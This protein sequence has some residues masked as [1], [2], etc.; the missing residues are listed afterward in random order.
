MTR[1]DILRI[2]GS[3]LLSL[4]SR[5]SRA[6]FGAA[7]QRS[8]K[9]VIVIGAGIAG[10]SCAY[11]LVRR[12]HDVAVLEA[13]QRTGGHVRT[14]HDPLEDGLY[15]EV[16]AE[17]FNYPEYVQYWRYVKEFELTAL[18]HPL[19]VNRVRCLRDQRYTEEDLQRPAVLQELG[20]K[21]PEVDFLSEH[22][23]SDLPHLYVQPYIDKIR[24]ESDPFVDGLRALDDLSLTAFLKRE[25]AS[26]AAVEFFGSSGSAL[27][28]VWAAAL[29]KLRGA[30]YYNKQLYRLKDGNECMT[31]AFT[32]RLGGRVQLDCPVT[33]IEHG[34]SGVTVTYRKRGEKHKRDADY[35]VSAISL[36]NLRQIP[37]SPAWPEAKAYLIQELPYTIKARVVFQSRTRFWQTDGVTPN[38]VFSDPLLQD[39]WSMAEEVKTPRGILVSNAA[40]LAE[41]SNSLAAFR[42]LYPGKS[43]DVEQTIVHNWLKDPWAGVCERGTY[44]PG[45]LSR[46]WPEATRPSGRIYFAGAYAAAMSWGQEAALESANRVAEEIDGS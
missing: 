15:A 30:D 7:P 36:V 12:G 13:S 8:N 10:L 18:P 6:L 26:A 23:W 38:W 29:K 35:L 43:A 2:G 3:T 42:K 24:D 37:V 34:S 33:G 28:T 1:R 46:L 14:I 17:H 22:N 5:H 20:F 25:N 19:R 40:V 4:E 21:Q 45:Q 31:K 27:Q 44:K 41:S 32:Q 39:L 11:E 9:S 16:G